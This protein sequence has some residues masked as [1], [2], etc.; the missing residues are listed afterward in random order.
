MRAKAGNLGAGSNASQDLAFRKQCAT[1]AVQQLCP[2]V[3]I[4]F[5]P[6]EKGHVKCKANPNPSNPA[7]FRCARVRG[8]P[9]PTS[10]TALA[11]PRR[12]ETPCDPTP[13]RSFVL[14]FR[15]L[16]R[17]NSNPLQVQFLDARLNARGERDM[18]RGIFPKLGIPPNAYV[19]KN[20]LSFCPT[21]G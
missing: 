9:Q 1:H 6:S 10:R 13:R 12:G 11:A 15:R 2:P 18:Q 3:K 4:T 20:V 8:S 7:L 5:Q 14:F 21:Q 17:P 19:S 16:H